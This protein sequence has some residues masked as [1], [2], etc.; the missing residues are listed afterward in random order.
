MKHVVIVGGG[1]AGLD[2]ARKLA[3]RGHVLLSDGTR[4][5]TRTVIWAGGQKASALSANLGMQPG[6]GS[7]INA[8]PD[9]TV[10]GFDGVYGLGDFA[11]IAG[12]DGKPL[13]QLASVVEQSGKW[14][15]RNI[16]LDIAGQSKSPSATSTR[17]SWP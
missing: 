6:H 9:L 1:F 13:P 7:R 8:Q 3:A 17:A 11:N 2:C 14:C 15:A 10:K 5:K 4:I 12:K 16:A